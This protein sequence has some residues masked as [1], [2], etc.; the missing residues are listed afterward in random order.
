[1]RKNTIFQMGA[2]TEAWLETVQKVLPATVT[3]QAEIEPPSL[4]GKLANDSLRPRKGHRMSKLLSLGSLVTG[5][6]V[7]LG[8]LLAAKAQASSIPARDSEQIAAPADKVDVLRQIVADEIRILQAAPPHRPVRSPLL[9]ALRS[10]TRNGEDPQPLPQPIHPYHPYIPEP[11]VR[12]VST[13][14][15]IHPVNP[16]GFNDPVSVPDGGSTGLMLALALGGLLRW[17]PWF[18]QK[19]LSRCIHSQRRFV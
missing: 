14:P 6:A 12:P 11:I 9:T 13:P 2:M 3:A 16:I 7:A 8:V 19:L 5:V 15:E 17:T 18:N 10:G 4:Y 1:M